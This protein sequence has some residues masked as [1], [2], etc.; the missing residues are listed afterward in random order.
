MEHKFESPSTLSK[1]GNAWMRNFVDCY[2]SDIRDDF[3]RATTIM[4]GTLGL[5]GAGIGY[6]ISGEPIKG[7]ALGAFAGVAGMESLYASCVVVHATRK[8]LGQ[9]MRSEL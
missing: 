2:E 6:F 4:G 8:T 1:F 9:F 3:S 5:A 7:F